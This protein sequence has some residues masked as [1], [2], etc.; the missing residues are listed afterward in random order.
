MS[1]LRRISI[2]QVLVTLV[3]ATILLS[4]CSGTIEGI[5]VDGVS[6]EHTTNLPVLVIEASSPSP[7][8][9]ISQTQ[10][11][12]YGDFNRL[13][14]TFPLEN[15]VLTE[16]VGI[17]KYQ[18]QVL[19]ILGSEG[20]ASY[21]EVMFEEL[22]PSIR[23]SL[24]KISTWDITMNPGLTCSGVIVNHNPQDKFTDILTARHCFV[25]GSLEIPWDPGVDTNINR[26]TALKVAL[27]TVGQ[28]H[29]P[30]GFSATNFMSV[31]DKVFFNGEADMAIIR[32]YDH[33]ATQPSVQPPI[34]TIVGNTNIPIVATA[35][36]A[37]ASNAPLVTTP[38]ILPVS[39]ITGL[40]ASASFLFPAGS[41]FPGS[42]GGGVFNLKGGDL[43]GLT[44]AD[45]DTPGAY[46]YGLMIPVSL[47][48][49]QHL[50]SLAVQY[51]A[52]PLP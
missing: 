6:G 34:P 13:I 45:L 8:S 24:V 32:I 49:V 51:G 19:Q 44:T 23:N 27:F 28:P 31:A 39:N 16:P 5:P 11:T 22:A 42:S 4:A 29:L 9:E 30:E 33:E 36:F 2:N 43:I 48:E 15:G 25:D 46:P 10:A 50:Q 20:Y 17:M 52:P 21:M 14:G 12:Q 3:G 35:N 40:P 37:F 18:E 26:I 38:Y 47:S 1:D 41:T 7:M